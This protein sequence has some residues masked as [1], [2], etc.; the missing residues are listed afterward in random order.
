MHI[1]TSARLGALLLVAM[2][3]ASCT[4]H[5]AKVLGPIPTQGNGL[6]Q[7]YVSIGN[8][9]TAGMQSS[10]INDSTQR[11]SFAYLL[12]QQMGTRF[13]YPSFTK[14]GCPPPTG[15]WVTQKLI[16][17]LAP[18]PNECAFRDATKATDIL[19]NVAVPGTYAAD[20]TSQVNLTAPTGLFSLMLGGMTQIQKAVQADPTFVTVW[21]GSNEIL[22][23]ASTGMLVATPGI[24]GSGLVPASTFVTQYATAMNQLKTGATHLKGGVLIGAVDAAN[25]PRFFSADSLATNATFKAQFDQLTGKT[26]TLIGCGA[27][28]YLVSSEIISRIRSGAVPAV[29]S[30]AKN[31]PQPP[32]GDVFMIDPTELQTL[33]STTTAYNTYIKAKADSLGFAYFD[34]NP[35]LAALRAAKLV[36]VL[37]SLLSTNA[38]FGTYLSLDGVHPTAVAQKLIANSLID[39]INTK[40]GTSLAKIP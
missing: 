11:Q 34:P 28:G 40:Y 16:D 21:V 18:I 31:Q 3:A 26:N 4:D 14:P 8:S 20:L 30:C 37:P 36:P 25:A 15:N 17:S 29:V 24:P 33:Q 32:L 23:A 27:S 10:G 39:V 19:N 2:V 7:T 5:A 1:R 12:A 22:T 13:A 6:F 35:A 38:P 9:I